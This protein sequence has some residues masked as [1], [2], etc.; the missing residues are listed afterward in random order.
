MKEDIGKPE[1]QKYLA[2]LGIDASKPENLATGEVQNILLARAST[3]V[4]LRNQEN[5][6]KESPDSLKDIDNLSSLRFT[7]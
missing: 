7:L 2:T 6:I 5:I 1:T 4:M 3:Q